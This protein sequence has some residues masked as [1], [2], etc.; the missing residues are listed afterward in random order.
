MAETLLPSISQQALILE[1]PLLV[2]AK[3][4]FFFILRNVKGV[5]C[6]FICDVLII[7]LKSVELCGSSKKK[8]GEIVSH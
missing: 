5:F 1:C 6:F 3:L 8:R 7:M 2:T 4:L